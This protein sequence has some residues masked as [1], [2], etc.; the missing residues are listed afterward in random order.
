MLYPR[1]RSK[2]VCKE[3]LFCNHWVL[4]AQYEFL[5][6]FTFN[7]FLNF[8][9]KLVSYDSTS[10]VLFFNP[11]WQSDFWVKCSVCHLIKLSFNKNYW[12]FN[13]FFFF[14]GGALEPCCLACRISAP[15]PGI[16][17]A[18]PALNAWSLSHWT[19][20]EVLV[21]L[22][23][24]LHF[25]SHSVI[26][27]CFMLSLSLFLCLSFMFSCIRCT[28]SIPLDFFFYLFSWVIFL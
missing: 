21:K 2:Y 27:V 28:V 4:S 11:Y 18:T 7:P 1:E 13:L 14:W 6:L 15:R 24:W 9:L 22:L 17:S 20:K 12:F 5:H 23:V 3:R 25:L 10:L 16:Q 19:T 8:N 26:S